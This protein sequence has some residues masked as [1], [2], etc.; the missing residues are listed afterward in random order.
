MLITRWKSHDVSGI[1]E[2]EWVKDNFVFVLVVTLFQPHLFAAKIDACKMSKK[3]G[4][5]FAGLSTY[6][7]ERGKT[8]LTSF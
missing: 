6:R 4:K 8:S 3:R 7:R 5:L 2:Y 1:F